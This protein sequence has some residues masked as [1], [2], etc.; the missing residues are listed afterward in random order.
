MMKVK[1][2]VI[3]YKTNEGDS[4]V[5]YAYDKVKETFEIALLNGVKPR[6]EFVMYDLA[7]LFLEDVI[8]KKVK[9]NIVLDFDDEIEI[10]IVTRLMPNNVTIKRVVVQTRLPV[11]S[12]FMK[13][14]ERTLIHLHEDN[15]I[16]FDK[17]PFIQMD[18]NTV[19]LALYHLYYI[20]VEP[21]DESKSGFIICE[22]TP[23]TAHTQRKELNPTSYI[24]PDKLYKV[25][26]LEYEEPEC[27]GLD[28]EYIPS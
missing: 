11:G 2:H 22:D 18:L 17:Q 14:M 8:N 15:R 21:L 24:Q 6:L 28:T 3:S 5:G 25:L 10:S 1:T 27:E 16:D 7:N 13:R 20:E 4:I 23:F 12:I 19:A 26:D 9:P